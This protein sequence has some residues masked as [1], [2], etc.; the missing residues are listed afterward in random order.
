MKVKTGNI[1]IKSKAKS[2]IINTAFNKYMEWLD[3]TERS[4]IKNLDKAWNMR[5]MRQ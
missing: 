2:V 4:S 5:Y 3:S 1:K